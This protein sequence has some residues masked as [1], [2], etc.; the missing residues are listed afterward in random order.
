MT[1][2]VDASVLLRI[3]AGERGALRDWR[4]ITRPLS[5]ELIRV[6]C[7]R[8]IDRARIRLGLNDVEI[9]ERRAA[10][11]EQ[12]DAFDLVELDRGVLERAAEPFPTEVGSLDG[13]HLAT[14]VLARTR[15]PD[16]PLATH[17]RQLA[18]AAR[19]MG[20]RVLGASTAS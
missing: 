13:V 14:A 11:L 19:S 15:I 12:L 6:E 8:T 5:S 10:L 16:L 20:F 18:I 9:A 3:V 4:K 1:V 7:L 2:Y 17:G